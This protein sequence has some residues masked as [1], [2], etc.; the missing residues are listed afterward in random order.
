[1]YAAAARIRTES[2]VSGSALSRILRP[3]PAPLPAPPPPPP[4]S[5]GSPVGATAPD[6]S[7][8]RAALLRATYP[9]RARQESA[10]P[11]VPRFRRVRWSRDFCDPICYPCYL[12][13]DLCDLNCYLNCYLCDFRCYLAPESNRGHNGQTFAP[14]F[15]QPR[16]RRVHIHL[17]AL[18]YKPSARFPCSHRLAGNAMQR[19]KCRLIDLCHL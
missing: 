6:S 9:R 19:R 2:P 3:P 13:C 17:I 12:S 15:F 16:I 14:I 10:P 8:S 18:Q 1:M 4:I 11:P 5:G 7:P